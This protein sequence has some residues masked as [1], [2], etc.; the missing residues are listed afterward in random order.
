[1]QDTRRRPYNKIKRRSVVFHGSY[2]HTL[3]DESASLTMSMWVVNLLLKGK[4]NVHTM[5]ERPNYNVMPSIVTVSR[6]MP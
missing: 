1:M 4:L 3:V 5:Y 6:Q 2:T